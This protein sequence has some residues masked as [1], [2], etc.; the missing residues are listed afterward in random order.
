LPPGQA[1]TIGGRLVE[2]A[3]RFP[4]SGER[5]LVRGL[6]LDVVLATPT[7]VERVLVRRGSPASTALDRG[8]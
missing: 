5:F 7:R 4:V 1:A 3:G 2:L 8:P 6:E